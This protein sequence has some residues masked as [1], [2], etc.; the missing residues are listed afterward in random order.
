MAE[1]SENNPQ[2]RDRYSPLEKLMEQALR[3][4]GEFSPATMDGEMKLM[5]LE[6]ANMIIDEIRQH[7][8][9]D[10]TP[11]DYYTDLQQARAIPDPIIVAGL[12]FLYA[13][14][15]GSQ[16]TP[17]KGQLY[18]R[19]MNQQ[20]WYKLNG[21]TPIRIRPVDKRSDTNPTNGMPTE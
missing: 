12:D 14:Q 9:Y 7:P 2:L 16:A 19:Q 11:I 18:F 21:N 8:Y 4:Y 1:R 3:R 20:L 13:T 6:F 10:G 15:Q 5:F 17:I